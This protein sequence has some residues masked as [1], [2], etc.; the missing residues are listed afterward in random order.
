[1]Q[2]VEQTAVIQT[3][4]ETVIDALSNVERIPSWATVSGAIDNVQ[5]QGVGMTYNW[6][7]QESGLKFKGK[8][9][10]IEQTD[11][12]LITKTTGDVESIWTVN[13]TPVG[14]KSTVI[15]VVVEY[16]LPYAFVEPLADIV[17]QRLAKPEVADENMK[18]FK[19]MVE[20][21]SLP[22]QAGQIKMAPEP[23]AGRGA[24]RWDKPDNCREAGVLLLLYPHITNGH[25]PE[26]HVLL[27]RRTEYPGVHS[28]QISFPGGRR[29]GQ[30]SLQT[31]ALREA[32]EE[33]GVLPATLEI[34]G[35]LSR[36]YTPPSNFC[37]YPFVGFSST[38]SSFRLDPQ[39]VA[40]LIETPLSL[41][42]NPTVRKEEIWNFE[43]YGQRRVP[44]FD[45]FG[46]KVW[47]ATAMM[48]SEFLTLLA[49]Q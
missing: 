2:V 48:L 22:G 9:E 40:E 11:N 23:P 28:G 16:T 46:H 32:M 18:R 7:F 1:M 39:E 5:G 43:E 42:L 12:S 10:V 6:R 27:T 13:L 38:R 35:Q 8:S 49:D 31:T 15:R 17:M 3:S 24:N 29:E 33:V 45:I 30:E 20:A 36:L 4:I 14:K 37:I 21:G 44:F 41:L 34:I 25:T 47:G 19:E 26:L